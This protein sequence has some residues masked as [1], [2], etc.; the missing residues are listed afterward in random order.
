MAESYPY[1]VQGGGIYFNYSDRNF[2]RKPQSD[3]GWDWGPAFV[4]TGIWNSIKSETMNVEIV[5]RTVYHVT[6]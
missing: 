3:F 4:P 1:F 5:I 2:V 6:P